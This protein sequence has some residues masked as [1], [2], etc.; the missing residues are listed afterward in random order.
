[1]DLLQGSDQVTEEAS[2][3]IVWRIEG[4]PSGRDLG[5]CDPIAHQRRLA[6]TGWSRDHCEFASKASIQPLDQARAMD[7]LPV[8]SG[9]VQLGG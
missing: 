2:D 9:N 7:Q 8:G 6:V 5:A 4:E 3:V 1:M